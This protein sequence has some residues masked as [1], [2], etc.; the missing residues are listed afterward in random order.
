LKHDEL[1]KLLSPVIATLGLECLGVEFG[2]HAGN[3]L[4]R[5]YI[6]AA[7]RTV[8]IEDCEAVSRE[9]SAALD[10]NDPVSGRYTLEVSSPG[11]DRP[12]FAPAQFARFLG[13]SAKVQ[14]NVPL[15]GRRK[16]SGPIKAVEGERITLEQDGVPVVIEHA[17]VLKA[18]LV[19]D[20][21]P[22]AKEV[23]KGRKK[24]Q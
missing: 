9:V 6:D 18:N 4:V 10:L 19:Y 7:D 8:T 12:L 14:L 11:L 16:F 2:P 3:S 13:Q 15:T 17:N 21:G 1:T 22:A 24:K 5:I 23:T 20:F